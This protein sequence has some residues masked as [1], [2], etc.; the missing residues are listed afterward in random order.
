MITHH[1]E[2][3]EEHSACMGSSGMDQ[4]GGTV[5]VVCEH[6]RRRAGHSTSVRYLASVMT[7][8]GLSILVT[9]AWLLWAVGGAIALHADKLENKRPKDAGFSI[10]PII[11]LFPA[12][13]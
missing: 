12:I 10:V 5:P 8:L 7:V 4:P 3:R 13:A 6:G 2:P 1:T 9:L 11:P